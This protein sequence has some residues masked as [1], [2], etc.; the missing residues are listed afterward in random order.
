[1][2][3]FFFLP[4]F[5]IDLWLIMMPG[6]NWLNYI[7]LSKCEWFPFS[8]FF[9]STSTCPNCLWVPYWEVCILY[10]CLRYKQAVFCYEELILSQPTVPLFHLAYADVSGSSFLMTHIFHFFNCNIFGSLLWGKHVG[11]GGSLWKVYEVCK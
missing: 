3:G 5:I 7:S 6:E 10:P 9:R 1:M 8:S 2:D 11:R 4:F